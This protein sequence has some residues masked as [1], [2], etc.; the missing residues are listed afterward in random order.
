MVYGSNRPFILGIDNGAL[1]IVAFIVSAV[2]FGAATM[3]HAEVKG[4]SKKYFWCGFVFGLFGLIY[5]AGLPLSP[6]KRKEEL[7]MLAHT[8]S[9]LF[10]FLRIKQ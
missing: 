1:I 4:Y 2:L 9:D 8:V 7:K 10:S 5:T 6:E 3:S